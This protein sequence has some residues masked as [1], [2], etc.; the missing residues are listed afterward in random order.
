ML[1]MHSNHDSDTEN[2]KCEAFHVD[3]GKEFGRG[4]RRTKNSTFGK[5][6]SHS[7]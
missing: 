6:A 3:C 5:E 7:D 4:V 1:G 2:E